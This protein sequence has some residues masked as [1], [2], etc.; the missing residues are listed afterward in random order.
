MIPLIRPDVAF[1]EV[2]EDIRCIL[3]SG[4]LTAGRFVAEFE[5]VIAETVGARHAISTPSA[6]AALEL[7]LRAAGVGPGDEV[8]VSDFSFPA[9]GNVVVQVGA[10]PVFVDCAPGSFALDLDDAAS[11]VTGRTVAIIPVHPFGQPADLRAV[12]ALA[13]RHHLLVIEDAACALGSAHSGIR[14]GERNTGCFSFHPRKLVTT[15]E[16]GAITTNDDAL[17]QRLRTMRS[18]GGVP[19]RVGMD[20]V[21]NGVNARLGEIPAAIGLAQLRR[22]GEILLDRRRSA[23][24]YDDLLAAVAGVEVR[25][26]PPGQVWTHQSYVVMLDKAVDRDRVVEGLRADGIESTLGTYAMHL[27]PAF[28]RFVG[29]GGSNPNSATAQR[30][31]LTLPLLPG[32]DPGQIDLVAAAVADVVAK[33]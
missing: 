11:K 29:E 15:G 33:A 21:L 4:Q 22:L 18:H 20:F 3:A 8:L 12:D 26:E 30:C 13:S 27:H 9:S 23:Q 10:T 32:M 24:R 17:A 5:R 19:T 2:E 1:E 25:P 14:C 7:S 16:G 6:T 31:S 28:S